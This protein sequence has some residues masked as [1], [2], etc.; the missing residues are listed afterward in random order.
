MEQIIEPENEVLQFEPKKLRD[1]CNRRRLT[2]EI[3]DLQNNNF[4]YLGEYYP[5]NN[6][7]AIGFKTTDKNENL[8]L[9][10][11][12]EFYPFKPPNIW[13]ND[14]MLWI[15]IHDWNVTMK[16]SNVLNEYLNNN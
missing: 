8:F 3:T 5:S 13:H 2:F 16:I 6:T 1:R 12:P 11:L 4:N 15:S 7:N 9:V 10:V 14:R